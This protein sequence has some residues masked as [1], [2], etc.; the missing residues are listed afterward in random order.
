MN[1]IRLFALMAFML[2]TSHVAKSQTTDYTEIYPNFKVPITNETLNVSTYASKYKGSILDY[3]YTESN[4]TKVEVKSYKKGS[5]IEVFERPPFPAIH[6]VYKEFYP[7]GKLKQKGVFLPT[8]LKVGK[9]MECDERG[10]CT[11]TDHEI[12]RS[13]YGYN[14]ILGY[15]E[16]LKYYNT[17]DGNNWQFFFWYTPSESKWGVRVNKNG[18]QYKMYTF[19]STEQYDIQEVD[20]MPNTNVVEPT[21]TFIQ[22]EE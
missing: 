6:L 18:H 13:Q 2:L 20:L 5:N 14:E 19:D 9:W 12:G 22:K 11:V 17:S 15:L 8:Q 1:T 16:F 7:N 4:G 3:S 21:G 10:N